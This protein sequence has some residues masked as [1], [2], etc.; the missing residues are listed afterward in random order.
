[1]TADVRLNIMTQAS[2]GFKPTPPGS[3]GTIFYY[4]YTGGNGGSNNGNNGFDI[5]SS[6]SFDITFQ[7][8][9]GD[10]YKFPSSAFKNKDNSPDLS[11]TNTDS[12]VTVT[13]SCE[14]VGTWEYGVHVEV[15]SSGETFDCDPEITNRRGS[16]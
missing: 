9:D 4:K 7:G 16:M 8:T 6:E 1:M 12:T 14:T 3:D 2:S 10:T 15:I 5:G 13:D 11:A